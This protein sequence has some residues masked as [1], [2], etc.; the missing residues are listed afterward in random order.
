M[1]NKVLFSAALADALFMGSGILELT[2]SLV[3][4]KD[5]NSDPS[6]GRQAL[7]NVVYQR[8]PLNAGIVNAGFILAAF[9][10][11]IPGLL[12]QS[13]RGWVKLAGYL[14]TFC[15]VFTMCVGV[16]LWVMTMRIGQDFFSVYMDLEPE[17]QGL[18]QTSFEC[19]GYFNSTSPA[20]VTNPTCPSPAAATLLRGCQKSIAN[21]ANLLL[22]EIFTALF[23]VVGVDAFFVL[24][25]ACLSKDRKDREWY[26]RVDRKKSYW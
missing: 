9:V 16:Y 5:M 6:D 7:R 22:D 23:G 14:V 8:M 4:Q 3:V 11:T 19:C 17:V 2:F 1:V 24:A 10:A 20:F 25:L 21:F 15:A 13:T 26:R 12:M 18:I